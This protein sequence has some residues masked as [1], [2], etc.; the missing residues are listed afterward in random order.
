MKTAASVQQPA[1]PAMPAASL[2]LF[3]DAYPDGNG[4]FQIIPR[5][6]RSLVMSKRGGQLVQ[7]VGSIDA[8]KILG[9]GRACIHSLINDD[10]VGKRMI[11]YRF[12]SKR[13]GKRVFDVA[14][15]LAYREWTKT[16]ED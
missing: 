3:A 2:I 15:L 6:P 9:I 1:K 16:L 10:P 7:E 13:R 11:K 12:T 4:G 5:P 8:C 14:S